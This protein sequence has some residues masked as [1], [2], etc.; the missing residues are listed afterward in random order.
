MPV[1]RPRLG[2]PTS[3]RRLGGERNATTRPSVNGRSSTPLARGS[4]APSATKPTRSISL[5]MARRASAS[6]AISACRSS[7]PAS[8]ASYTSDASAMRGTSSSSIAAAWRPATLRPNAGRPA[9]KRTSTPPPPP[10]TT[11]ERSRISCP[12]RSMSISPLF[13]LPRSPRAIRRAA[14]PKRRAKKSRSA[15]GRL[16]PS[17]SAGGKPAVS[18]RRRTRSLLGAANGSP[19]ARSRAS[20]SWPRS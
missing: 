5:S 16:R 9:T 3:T 12:G 1:T 6:S 15:T 7:A 14:S 11:E 8:S 4:T 18:A 19:W 20:S 2:S 10:N 17:S 13:P